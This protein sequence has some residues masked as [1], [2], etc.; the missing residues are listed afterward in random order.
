MS[1][2]VVIAVLMWLA[3]I[4][5]AVLLGRCMWFAWEAVQQT[6]ESIRWHRDW[7]ERF[8]EM[9]KEDLLPIGKA[10]QEMKELDPQDRKRIVAYVKWIQE[11]TWR[12]N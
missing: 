2:P 12:D 9:R 8:N 5:M 1:G 4:A 11:Q 10:L 7:M 3:V 6:V